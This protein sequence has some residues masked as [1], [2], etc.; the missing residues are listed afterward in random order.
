MRV[1][2]T[3]GSGYIGAAVVEALLAAGCEVT[4]L[5]R[6]PGS[7]ERL[8]RAGCRVVSGDM[9]APQAWLGGL[10][11]LDAV[12]HTAATFDAEMA[13]AD[14]A[15]LDGLLEHAG[16]QVAQGAARLRLV[17]TGGC[18]LYGPV[19]DR[20]AVEGA[21]FDP[22]RDF[23]YMVEQ[24]ARLFAAPEVAAYVVHPAMVW[25][26]AGG[27]IERFLEQARHGEAPQVV[28]AFETR[29]PLVHRD[30]LAQLYLRAAAEGV[31][32]ADYHGVAERGVAVGEIA[33]AVSRRFNAPAPVVQPLAEA[34]AALGDWAAGLA[35]D[36]TMDATATRRDLGWAPARPGILA[37]I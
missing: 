22:L 36:V 18:W 2:V 14:A 30:D 3:G 17:Y 15:L 23:A 35:F 8:R 6:S 5:A 34:V 13:A 25:D 37:S 27:A 21:P 24:R 10:G 31:D 20:T 9:R 4:A 16:R 7:G 32:G 19:G 28:G 1:L 26:E 11:P 29:W 12:I 33:A